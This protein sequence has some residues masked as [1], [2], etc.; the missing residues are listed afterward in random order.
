M[1]EVDKESP[2]ERVVITEVTASEVAQ[3]AAVQCSA[4][5]YTTP[6]CELRFAVRIHQ[7]HC[8]AVHPAQEVLYSVVQKEVVTEPAQKEGVIKPKDTAMSI[9]SV[10]AEQLSK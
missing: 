4:C 1:S 8:D 2:Q 3:E 7:I 6:E 5:Q 9:G 10:K